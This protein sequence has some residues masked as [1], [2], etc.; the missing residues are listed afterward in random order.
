MTCNC[1]TTE[2]YKALERN[3]VYDLT[4]DKIEEPWNKVKNRN[5]PPKPTANSNVIRPCTTLKD[6]V[7]FDSSISSDDDPK[8]ISKKR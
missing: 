2:G 7:S 4:P 3:S 6:H 8:G 1:T 5:P